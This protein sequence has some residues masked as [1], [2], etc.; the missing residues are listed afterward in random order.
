M[1]FV[2]IILTFKPETDSPIAHAMDT[3]CHNS[4]RFNYILSA[5]AKISSVQLSMK[6]YVRP[7]KNNVIVDGCRPAWLLCPTKL[8]KF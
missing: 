7:L 4:K 1:S 3:Y 6:I 2:S 8:N 5:V